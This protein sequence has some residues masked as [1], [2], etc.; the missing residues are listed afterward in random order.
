PAARRS[1]S[2]LRRPQRRRVAGTGWRPGNPGF[3]T[4]PRAVPR[5]RAVRAT[6]C[7][8]R[9]R[10]YDRVMGQRKSAPGSAVTVTLPAAAADCT[11]PAEVSGEGR[12]PVVARA[13][14]RGPPPAVIVAGARTHGGDAELARDSVRH[15]VQGVDPPVRQGSR[16]DGRAHHVAVQEQFALPRGRQRGR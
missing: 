11:A 2:T 6:R 12:P 4:E 10:C 3:E 9:S 7:D 14:G 16:G 15:L 1:W 8:D 5:R 13:G